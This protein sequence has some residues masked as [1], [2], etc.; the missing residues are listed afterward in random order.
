M[1]PK[2]KRR[3]LP[4]ADLRE[5]V[6]IGGVSAASLSEILKKLKAGPPIEATSASSVGRAAAERFDIRQLCT[7]LLA[8]EL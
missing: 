6:S 8:G 1:P 3:K 7:C 4:C 2:A 5:L